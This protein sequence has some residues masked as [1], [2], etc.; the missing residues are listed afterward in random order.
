DLLRMSVSPPFTDRRRALPGDQPA[1]RV[2][3]AIFPRAKVSYVEHWPEIADLF[4][5]LED[6]RPATC[7]AYA[8]RYL[9]A[10]L[11]FPTSEGAN[12]T[13]EDYLAH[14]AGTVIEDSE[15]QEVR[16]VKARVEA[17]GLS[18][19]EAAERFPRTW[20]GWPLRSSDDDV[21]T[22]TSPTGTARAVAVGSGGALVTLPVPGRGRD[23]EVTM[24]PERFDSLLDL[25][26]AHLGDW[27][28][29]PIANLEVDQLLDATSDAYAPGSL[30][31]ADPEASIPREHWGVGHFVGI[32]AFWRAGDGRRWV[33]L[34]D[35]YKARGFLGYVPMPA[36][37]LRRAVVREDG[38]DGGLLLVMRRDT[39]EAAR[40]A[41]EAFGLE[42]RMW[43]NGSLEPEG[44]AWS[45]GR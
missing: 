2:V 19:A 39:L 9:L 32:G 20:Y 31:G 24:T 12:T 40:R 10:P 6:Q 8:A 42:I 28:V 37:S 27:G 15:L 23:G 38:R 11:G 35:T 18:D 29:H 4:D 25:I 26:E 3:E 1:R 22:G 21:V 7:G 36:K 13:R 17:L 30:A 45:L 16:E 33:L 43:G 14:L 34:L 44:W 5:R 41:I